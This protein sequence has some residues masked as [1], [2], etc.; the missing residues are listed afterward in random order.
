MW[1]HH[2]SEAS[3]AETTPMTTVTASLGGRVLTCNFSST[4]SNDNWQLFPYMALSAN[5]LSLCSAGTQINFY[6]ERGP[7]LY[8]LAL[9]PK[10]EA[11][12]AHDDYLK[13]KAPA[14]ILNPV[15]CQTV[16]PN[17][18]VPLSD[19]EVVPNLR[20]KLSTLPVVLDVLCYQS[21]RAR[22]RRLRSPN[23]KRSC[24]EAPQ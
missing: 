18:V 13:M 14:A 5:P 23:L 21:R 17:K 15:S 22:M 4:C 1:A 2:V 6:V 16:H 8:T 9:A 11:S 12:L 20:L 7:F 24:S 3:Y 10:P 19:S